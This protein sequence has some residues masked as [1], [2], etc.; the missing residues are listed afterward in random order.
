MRAGDFITSSSD[1]VTLEVTGLRKADIFSVGASG[2]ICVVD[3]D[4]ETA[5]AIASELDERRDVKITGVWVSLDSL[6]DIEQRLRYART[7]APAPDSDS[8]CAAHIYLCVRGLPSLGYESCDVICAVGG[9]RES[10]R[11]QR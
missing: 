11:A 1:P 6:D 7:A 2:K 9:R 10:Q 5:E 3:A 4:V 8:D